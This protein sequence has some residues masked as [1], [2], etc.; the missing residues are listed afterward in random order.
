MHFSR[1]V[2]NVHHNTYMSSIYV[3]LACRR[4]SVTMS[5]KNPLIHPSHMLMLMLL[6]YMIFRI[7]S[8]F[9]FCLPYIYPPSRQIHDFINSAIKCICCACHL[10]NNIFVA[11]E[12]CIQM[13][14][15][16]FQTSNGCHLYENFTDECQS[17]PEQR[18]SLPYF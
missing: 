7:F 14:V 15:N 1:I 5:N 10:L 12:K 9:L 8:F 3:L 6:M 2:I 4:H 17:F 18:V 11:C 16:E 13:N